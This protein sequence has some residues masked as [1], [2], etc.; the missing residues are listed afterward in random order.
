M[1]PSAVKRAT[2]EVIRSSAAP[3]CKLRAAREARDRIED[4]RRRRTQLGGL[5]RQH[6]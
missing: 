3:D 4:R 2:F 1:V 5:A 6:V